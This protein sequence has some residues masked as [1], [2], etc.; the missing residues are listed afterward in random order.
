MPEGKSEKAASPACCHANWTST[1]ASALIGPE[2][3]VRRSIAH[4]RL[5]IRALQIEHSNPSAK[6]QFARHR[7]CSL[8]CTDVGASIARQSVAIDRFV[9]ASQ[10]SLRRREP[11]RDTQSW[12]VLRAFE[13]IDHDERSLWSTFSVRFA[14][15][16][17]RLG[18]RLTIDGITWRQCQ[19]DARVLTVDRRRASCFEH[20][21]D[22][23]IN[24]FSPAR[25][26]PIERRDEREPEH[27]AP[28]GHH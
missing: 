19:P 25:C 21:V 20:H 6:R 2:S 23:G 5:P 17:T 22:S 26:Q 16:V 27:F 24:R 28:T 1:R 14:W 13:L 4:V 8:G 18:P 11:V 12:G 9:Q 7:N 10:G 15:S 3:S